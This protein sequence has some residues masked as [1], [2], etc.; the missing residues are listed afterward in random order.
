[1]QTRDVAERKAFTVKF[2]WA[3]RELAAR[4]AHFYRKPVADVL[5]DLMLERARDLGPEK[6]AIPDDADE[7]PPEPKT[8]PKRPASKRKARK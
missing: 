4:L 3:E 6:V 8:A 1:M 2:S 5:R 7:P